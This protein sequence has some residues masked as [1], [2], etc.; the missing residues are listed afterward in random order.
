MSDLI[1]GL[2]ERPA[3]EQ[4]TGVSGAAGLPSL[5]ADSERVVVLEA[6]R[7]E[8][9]YWQDLWHYRELFAILAWRDVSVRYKQTVIG[10]AWHESV[11]CRNSNLNQA[12]QDSVWIE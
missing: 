3:V 10:V 4:A 9:N 2:A 8:R 11:N 6:G 5:T 7:T 1:S 12:E